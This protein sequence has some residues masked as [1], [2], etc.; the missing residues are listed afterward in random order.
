M[1][2]VPIFGLVFLICGEFTPLV[3][4]LVSNVVPWTCRIPRQIESDRQTLESRRSISFR[5]LTTP[6]PA[7]ETTVNDL[8]RMQ[9]L[10]INWSLGLSS[11]IWDYFGGMLPGLPTWV[12]RRRVKSR[13]EYLG[14][15]DRLI[16]EG[17]GVGMME[18][19]EVRMACVERGIDVLGREEGDMRRELGFWVKGVGEKGVLGLLLTR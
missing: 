16:R 18:E 10:H 19:E 14:I 5:N 2:R 9:L 11:S 15:D 4:I 1:R 3:V 8:G 6:P 7:R 13:V 17:G 12:L